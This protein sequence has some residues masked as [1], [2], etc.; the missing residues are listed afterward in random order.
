MSETSMVTTPPA[1]SQNHP[2]ATGLW[3]FQEALYAYLETSSV[4]SPLLGTPARVYDSPPSDVITPYLLIGETRSRAFGGI[5]G[6]LEH[7]VSLRIISTYEGRREVKQIM[8][9]IYM[10]LHETD[11]PLEEHCL[12]SLRFVFADVFRRQ[13]RNFYQGVMRFRAVTTPHLDIS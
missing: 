12:V 10:V 6:G 8:D 7:E 1:I 11:L 5:K 3:P 9:S 4:L 13:D 2:Q